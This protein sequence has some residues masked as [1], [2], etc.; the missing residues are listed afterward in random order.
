M[1]KDIMGLNVKMYV[2]IY[3]IFNEA[4]FCGI[5]QVD[6]LSTWDYDRGETVYCYS[7]CRYIA[8]RYK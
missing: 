8:V 4:N 3:F 7:P 2:L 5:L 6:I 1:N